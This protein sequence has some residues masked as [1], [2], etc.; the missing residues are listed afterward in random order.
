MAFQVPF[1]PDKIGHGSKER[2]SVAR[3]ESATGA[4]ASAKTTPFAPDLYRQE[5]ERVVRRFEVAVELAE[6]GFI[7]EFSKLISHLT[8]R[9]SR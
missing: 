3:P 8:E 9:L 2:S 4:R 6:Q 7:G 5:Q 1:R